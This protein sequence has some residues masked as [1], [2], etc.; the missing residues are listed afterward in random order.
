MPDIQKSS[1][2]RLIE[3]LNNKC[4]TFIFKGSKAQLKIPWAC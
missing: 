4:H 1:N 3:E 2:W